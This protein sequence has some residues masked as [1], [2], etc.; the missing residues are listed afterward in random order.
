MKR[1]AHPEDAVL[2]LYCAGDLSWFQMQAA[3]FHLRGCAHCRERL[4]EFRRTLDEL[5]SASGHLPEDL[6]W[7][8][9]SREMTANI[10]LGLDAGQ[11]VR[12]FEPAGHRAHAPAWRWPATAM[13]TALALVFVSV[14][15]LRPS[16]QGETGGQVALTLPAS[17]LTTLPDFSGGAKASRMDDE[18]GQV[19]ITHVYTE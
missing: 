7:D 15:V 6:N 18:T 10:H 19:I 17:T 1:Q 5:Q 13:A 16:P 3:R 2:A 8:A 12:P 9:L 4:T 14:W 11:I